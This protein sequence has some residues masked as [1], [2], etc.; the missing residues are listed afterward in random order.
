MRTLDEHA[1]VM[2]GV[3]NFDLHDAELVG[4]QHRREF[5]TLALSIV[6]ASGEH[7]EFFFEGVRQF[8]LVDYG[9]QNVALRV[10][11]TPES[12]LDQSEIARWLSWIFTTA[13]GENLLNAEK[14]E[15]LLRAVVAGDL[16]LVIWLPSWGAQAAVIAEKSEIRRG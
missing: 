9:T 1:G 16:L 2:T 13:E 12:D 14:R 11:W 6:C 4:V 15:S 5:R 3:C 10:M 8:R 7:A